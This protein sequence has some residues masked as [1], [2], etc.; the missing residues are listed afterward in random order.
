MK[1][2]GSNLLPTPRR[3]G[4]QPPA[5]RSRSWP[6]L[7]EEEV[8]LA[9]RK[10]ER[11]RRAYRQDIAHFLEAVGV[12][13]AEELRSIDHR[14]VIAW[15][16]TMETRREAPSTVRRR[17][18]ALS[19]LVP[20]SGE[21]RASGK[22]SR[23]RGR[24]PFH[25]RREGKTAAFSQ[26]QARTILDAPK[27][28]GLAGLRDRAILSV[29]LQTGARRAEIAG[30]LVKHYGMNQGYPSLFLQRKRNQ[31]GWVS[32]HPETNQRIK[33]YLEVAGH[34]D[35]TEGPLFRPVRGNHRTDDPLRALEPKAIDRILR[36][37][38]KKALAIERGFSAHS[39]RA[40]FITTALDNGAALE[41]VQYAVGHAHSSTTM[42]YDKRGNKPERSASFFANY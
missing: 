23:P 14:A 12:G 31:D 21:P 16:R 39:M 5:L 30:I 38:V 1:S 22:K 42:L 18:S 13:S 11:T 26:E 34:G 35:E 9:G 27:E 6:R 32:L 24:A 33:A 15:T 3:V 4:F 2:G 25:H 10:T 7:A 41:D 20:T 28:S 17:L 19:E 29:G 36:K 37:Y 8:W 40:T